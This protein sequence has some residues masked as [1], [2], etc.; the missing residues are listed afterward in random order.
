MAE[1]F[2]HRGRIE[3][4]DAFKILGVDA[5]GDEQ[6]IDSKTVGAGEVRAH[7]IPDRE[8]TIQLDRMVLASIACS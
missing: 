7:G 8:H 2:L 3:L 5:A 4:I 1:Q 6:A